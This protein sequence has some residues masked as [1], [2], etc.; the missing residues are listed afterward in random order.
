MKQ[1]LNVTLK[2]VFMGQSNPRTK[3]LDSVPPKIRMQMNQNGV[4]LQIVLF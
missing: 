3:Q 4:K 1:N 2:K